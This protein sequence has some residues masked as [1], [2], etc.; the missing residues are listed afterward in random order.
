MVGSL[1]KFVR[2]W[3]AECEV[4]LD[5]HEMAAAGTDRDAQPHS[6]KLWRIIDRLDRINH[7]VTA[8]AARR[9]YHPGNLR[10]R[11]SPCPPR[12]YR[13]VA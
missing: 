2:C 8:E 13:S 6:P 7:G 11:Q 3:F 1:A 12:D 9:F 5:N 10:H 4:V